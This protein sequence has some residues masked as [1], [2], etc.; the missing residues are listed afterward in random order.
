MQMTFQLKVR[1][2]EIFCAN[3][4]RKAKVEEDNCCL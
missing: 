2:C 1:D 3:E 4:N